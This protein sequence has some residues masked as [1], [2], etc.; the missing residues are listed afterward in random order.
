MNFK[1]KVVLITGATSGIGRTTAVLYAKYGAKVAVNG[2]ELN[3]DKNGETTI[4][5]IRKIG[6]EC[7]FIQGDVS[8]NDDAQRIVM[9]TVEKYGKIDILVNNAGIVLPGRVDNMSEEDFDKTM[10]V[11]VKGAFLV[12]KYAVLQMKK[13]GKGVIVN[14]ASVAALKGHT[15]RSAYSASKG[16]I[17]SLTKAMAADYVKDNIR[18][19][20]VCPGTTL[21]PA[22]E[23]KI[24]NAPD[25][26]AMRAAFIARQP[27]GRLGRPEE[28]AFAILFASCDE[29]EFMNGS[30]IVIDGGMTI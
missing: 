30:I 11:N 26:E 9:E 13:Q 18:V 8:K 12:S 15:D 2:R 16:A 24:V 28:I 23:E 4:D 1:D 27:M 3:K 20:C 5:E 7:I 25:P 6:G 19:N 17:V 29:A 10:A 14:V 22:V 21:T